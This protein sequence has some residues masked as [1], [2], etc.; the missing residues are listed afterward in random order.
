MSAAQAEVDQQI[1]K[2]AFNWQ[3]EPLVVTSRS[4]ATPMVP[5]KGVIGHEMQETVGAD[6]VETL[7]F[8][9]VEARVE[10]PC[11]ERDVVDVRVRGLACCDA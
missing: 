10:R 9:R 2:F 3:D 6:P 1:D 4:G 5:T 11:V 7:V 8:E